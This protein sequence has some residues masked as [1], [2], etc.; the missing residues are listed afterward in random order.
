VIRFGGVLTPPADTFLMGVRNA[1][2][3]DAD[4]Q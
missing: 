4:L 2:G 3:V 1:G